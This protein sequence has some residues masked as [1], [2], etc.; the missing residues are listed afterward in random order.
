MVSICTLSAGEA[1]TV[2]IA[3][4]L[5]TAIGVVGAFRSALCTV[6]VKVAFGSI[7]HTYG[8]LVDPFAGRLL[9][10]TGATGWA[11]VNRIPH[12]GRVSNV[13]HVKN[14]P[15]LGVRS[16]IADISIQR[17]VLGALPIVDAPRG[18]HAQADHDH[19]S[20]THRPRM[21]LDVLTAATKQRAE[22]SRGLF[23]LHRQASD[24]PHAHQG[25]RPPGELGGLMVRTED[26]VTWKLDPDFTWYELEI[27]TLK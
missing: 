24:A 8:S 4:L 12:V 16:G 21:H 15:G 18:G 14:V 3:V 2:D 11:R 5:L 1:S 7:D 9:D 22:S 10:G 19:R 26:A 13:L 6:D 17:P 27:S 20:D 23:H 25:D